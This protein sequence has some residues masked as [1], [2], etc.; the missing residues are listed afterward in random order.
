MEEIDFDDLSE[1]AARMAR[2]PS[3]VVLQTDQKLRSGS[4][5]GRY[6]TLISSKLLM[7]LPLLDPVAMPILVLRDIRQEPAFA[8]HPLT[9]SVPA[10]RSLIAA[11]LNRRDKN[12][13]MILCILNPDENVFDDAIGFAA[14]SKLILTFQRLLGD[15][16]SRPATPHNQAEAE[17]NLAEFSEQALDTAPTAKFLLDTLVVKRTL[18]AR[19][20]VSYVALR[21]WRKSIKQY[22]IS[23][24]ASIKL[25]PS[26]VIIDAVADEIATA[27]TQIYGND[28]IKAVVPIPGGS[29]GAK[30]SFSELVAKE[31]AI[32]LNTQ[33]APVLIGGNA[34]PGPSHPKKSSRLPEYR[35]ARPIADTVLIVDDVVTSGRRIELAH[36]ALRAGGANCFAVAWIGN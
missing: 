33:Y 16:A 2:A 18:R 21:T 10:V 27:T 34:E 26:Q 12:E 22:Q 25:K 4:V 1:L 5:Q 24:L 17:P 30:V 15:R 29:S 28:T 11:V 35:L 31:V 20:S 7:N 3:A 32:R 23:A 8:D 19:N 36:A 13:R 6:G 14:I 9:R